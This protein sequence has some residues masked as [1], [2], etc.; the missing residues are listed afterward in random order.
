M[1]YYMRRKGIGMPSDAYYNSIHEG[2]KDFALDT[3]F[4]SRASEEAH[5][6]QD[7]NINLARKVGS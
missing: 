7:L 3:K 6:Y 1:L 5:M 2:Y 4:L